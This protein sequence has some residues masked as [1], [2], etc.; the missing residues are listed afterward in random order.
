MSLG[1][2]II[3]HVFIFS[4]LAGIK[5]TKNITLLWDNESMS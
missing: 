5:K 3:I 2:E 1:L 4:E